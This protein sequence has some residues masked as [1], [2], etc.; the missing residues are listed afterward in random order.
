MKFSTGIFREI[1]PFE[2]NL[3][4]LSDKKLV[5]VGLS[6]KL[7]EAKASITIKDYCKRVW[8]KNIRKIT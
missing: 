5:N 7:L 4:K 6:R 1:Y 3:L 2:R 8:W